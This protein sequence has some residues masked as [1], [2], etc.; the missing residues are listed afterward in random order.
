VH[1]TGGFWEPEPENNLGTFNG[2]TV[3]QA[4]D[5]CCN[6]LRCAGFS[7]TTGLNTTAKGG[8][9]YKGQPL[10]SVYKD[11]SYD[12]FAK[13]SQVPAPAPPGPP[14]AVDITLDLADLD[15]YGPVR[16]FDIFAQK[17]MGLF[18][19]SYT[20]TAV[21]HHGTAFLRLQRV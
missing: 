18:N 5:A 21:P 9:F 6:D 1:T 14:Q 20:A 16:V 11:P 7:I 8:G 2:L 17:D 10:A 15:I 19:G 12:G 13:K 3:A 4:E